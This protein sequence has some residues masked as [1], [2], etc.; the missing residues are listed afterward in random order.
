MQTLTLDRPV[1]FVLPP[2]QPIHIALV[3]CGGTGSHIAQALARLAYHIR[4]QG[5]PPVTMTFIDGDTVDH[6]NVGRQLFSPGEI[7]KPK[8]RVLADRLN[9]ALGLSINALPEMATPQ[10]LAGIQPPYQ[11]VGV[12]VGAVDRASGRR[13]LHEA[14]AR[15][16]WRIWL[17]VGNERDWGKALLGTA[18]EKRQLHGAFALGGICTA[19]PAPSLCYPHLLDDLPIQPRAD[20]AAAMQDGVQSLMVNQ[21][22]AAVAG[23]YL[24][25][26]TVA[27]QVTTFETALDLASM[28]MRSTPITAATITAAAGLDANELTR[29]KG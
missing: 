11:S 14:L 27:R 6:T 25:Q 23:Q 10:L 16:S 22:M 2:S 19:L 7:G 5:K 20:C 15:S 13:A 26:L 12:L 17:D 9:A 1:P 21:A 4:S 29:R 24:Y 28:T 3:G 8:A 18:A